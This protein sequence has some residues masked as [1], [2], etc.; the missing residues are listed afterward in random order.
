MHAQRGDDHPTA[1]R[2]DCVTL[3]KEVIEVE[4]TKVICTHRQF[5]PLRRPRHVLGVDV[6]RQ[7]R[8]VAHRVEQVIFV[9][10]IPYERVD[11]GEIG[12]VTLHGG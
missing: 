9:I 8:I 7:S 10:Q 4:M 1:F 5:K 6:A 12:E 3:Q 11:G 2:V